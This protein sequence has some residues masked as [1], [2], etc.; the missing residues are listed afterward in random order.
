MSTEDQLKVEVRNLKDLVYVYREHVEAVE[1][2]RDKLAAEL[3]MER[4]FRRQLQRKMLN[5]SEDKVRCDY[6]K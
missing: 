1:A 2:E 6:E 5:K 3:E 4:N